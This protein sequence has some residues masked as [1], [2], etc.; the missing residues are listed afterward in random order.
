MTLIK[1]LFWPIGNIFISFQ[2]VFSPE[3]SPFS[4]LSNSVMLHC[5]C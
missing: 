2:T 1:I 5:L 4:S 3:L